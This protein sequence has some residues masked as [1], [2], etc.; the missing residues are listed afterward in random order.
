MT[1]HTMT[2][3]KAL[4]KSIEF[5]TTKRSPLNLNNHSC[6]ALSQMVGLIEEKKEELTNQIQG[7]EYLI[8]NAEDLAESFENDLRRKVG[9]QKKELD[10]LMKWQKLFLDA[11]TEVKGKK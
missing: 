8:D 7:T 10:D 9:L 2:L 11:W 3:T 4:H 5:E 1:Q 6:E